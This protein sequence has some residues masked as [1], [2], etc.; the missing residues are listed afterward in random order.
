MTIRRRG[1]KR[2]SGARQFLEELTGGPLTFGG[3]LHSIRDGEGMTLAA[4]AGRL[5]VSRQNLCDVEH[6]R[7]S[8]SPARAAEWAR[9]LGHSEGQFVRLALQDQ[10]SEAGLKLRVSVDAA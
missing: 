4:F 2:R 10:V 1:A 6:G 5:G 8:V 9:L 3:F 7:R